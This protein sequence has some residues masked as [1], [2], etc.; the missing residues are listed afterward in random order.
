MS[1]S[2]KLRVRIGLFVLVTGTVLAI[3]LYM[4]GIF[5]NVFR[6]KDG[7]HFLVEFS[8]APNVTPGTPVRRSG[9]KIG[10][11]DSMDLD[12]E[13][14]RVL[15]AVRIGR[16]Y[17][18][19]HNEEPTLITG[20]LSGDTSIDLLPKE[21]KP[22]EEVDRSPI[23][24]GSKI[25]GR[26]AASVNTLLNRATA[27]AQPAQESLGRISLALEKL[28]AMTPK[29]EATLEEYR[30][31]AKEGRA[32]LPSLRRTSTEIEGLAKDVR[33]VIPDLKNTNTAV[34][35]L[36]KDIDGAVPD[37][38][39]LIKE[40]ADA[41]PEVR[42]LIKSANQA[43]PDI[44]AFIKTANEAATEIKA[45][46]K[47]VG[48]AVP[49]ARKLLKD[50]NEVVPVAKDTLGEIK[51]ASK[52]WRMTGERANKLLEANEQAITNT[53]KG[54]EKAVTSADRAL[55]S[56]EKAMTNVAEAFNTENRNDL[57]TIL[58]NVKKTSDKAPSIAD[59][60]ELFLR[61]GR[62]TLLK[63]NET[64]KKVD[65]TFDA[66]NRASKPGSPETQGMLKNLS[67]GLDKF[68]HTMTD[69]ND[70]LRVVGRSD[71]SLRRFIADPALFNHLDD[72]ALMVTR[73]LP[74]L[75]RALK[76]VEV[77]ADKLARH[78]EALG[79][80]GV[81][82]PNTGLKEPPRSSN[83]PRVP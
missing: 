23:E 17:T 43:M 9:V 42:G 69:V 14:G 6:V 16:K 54:A 57:T 4:F 2:K 50:A 8:D 56:T 1:D 20:L 78:P 62:G 35:K 33:G 38:R 5:P 13:T 27:I 29:L 65:E 53:I 67:E 45:T 80:G 25:D 11:V 73:I 70:L 39:R 61:Q 82:R 79:L 74:R 7:T 22:G 71:G 19:R 34:Q 68:N 64:L 72:A 10:Q 75:D 51:E 21:V 28:S 60:T 76:D 40:S 18:L 15:I 77:F 3:L 49:D 32:T 26:L 30:L 83:Y 52:N 41:V 36:V 47:A 58:R 63:M 46:V 81:V 37:A 55:A 31:L 59:E 48:D 44:R 66:L 24:P 12:D